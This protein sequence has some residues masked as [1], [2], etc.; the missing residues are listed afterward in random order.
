[1]LLASG[2]RAG[3]EPLLAEAANTYRKLGMHAWAR[4]CDV[5]VGEPAVP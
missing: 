4:R 3:A 5:R 1:M 2:E